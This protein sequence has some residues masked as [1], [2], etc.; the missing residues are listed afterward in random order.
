MLVGE[1]SGFRQLRPLAQPLQAGLLRI[2]SLS[3]AGA[4]DTAGSNHSTSLLPCPRVTG[5]G[6]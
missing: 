6:V 4:N 3:N 1:P 2:I 5:L